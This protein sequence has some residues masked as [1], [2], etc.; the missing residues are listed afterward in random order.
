MYV[1]DRLCRLCK[2]EKPK[3]GGILPEQHDNIETII[4]AFTMAEDAIL[5]SL[6]L[7]SL[8]INRHVKSQDFQKVE[9]PKFFRK[10]NWDQHP[11]SFSAQAESFPMAVFAFEFVKCSEG[12]FDLSGGKT[13]D[14]NENSDLYS[15]QM[16]LRII[17][18]CFGHTMVKDNQLRIQWNI[19]RKEYKKRFKVKKI[20]LVLDARKLDGKEFKLKELGGNGWEKLFKFLNYLKEDLRSKL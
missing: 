15:A 18:N 9:F 4:T 6:T 11:K 1:K 3:Y 5:Y 2:N 20:G 14:P 19:K 16:I 10:I 13:V 7:S 8:I 12:Y 17:R